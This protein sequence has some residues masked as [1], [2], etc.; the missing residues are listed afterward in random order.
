LYDPL[1]MPEDLL[2]AHQALDRAVDKCYRG[3]KFENERERVE[4]LFELYEKLT[5]LLAV[6]EEAPRR[7][8]R[9]RKKKALGS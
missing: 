7:K 9:A 5:S 2:K 8:R 6:T 1:Y 4:H 3:K